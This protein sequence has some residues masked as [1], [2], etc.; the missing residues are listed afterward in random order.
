M[1]T[2]NNE[3][4]ILKG[5]CIFNGEREDLKEKKNNIWLAVSI[6]L[7]PYSERLVKQYLEIIAKH[8]REQALVFIAD[9]IAAINYKVLGGYGHNK[10]LK[11]AVEKGD[12]FIERYNEILKTLPP[13]M[14]KKIKIV[15]WRN[16]WTEKQEKMYKLIKEEYLSSPEFRKEVELP[17]IT[18]LKN[19]KRTIKISRVIKMAEY[20]LKELPFMLDGVEHEG[21]NYKTQLYPSYGKTSLSEIITKI[22]KGEA[23]KKLKEKLN[24]QGDHILVDS[25]I[26]EN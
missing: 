21:V 8:S 26:L 5:L 1:E 23:F 17:V 20:I 19:S 3:E 9:E 24:I 13:E 14:Q 16:V 15:R 25:P 11:R 2:K 7:K 10:S 4:E 22:Q 6:S 12:L 18:Y